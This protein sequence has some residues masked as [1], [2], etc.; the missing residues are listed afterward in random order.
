MENDGGK[1]G[2]EGT[3]LVEALL[4]VEGLPRAV[5]PLEMDGSWLRVEELGGRVELGIFGADD[6]KKLLSRDKVDHVL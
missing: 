1:D 2:R 4:H 5:I 6:F 3:A